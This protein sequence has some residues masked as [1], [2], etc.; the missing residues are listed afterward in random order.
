MIPPDI[1]PNE[2]A[3]IARLHS[4]ELLDGP[5]EPLIDRFTTLASGMTGM[6]I[7]LVSL[8]AESHAEVKSAVGSIAQGQRVPRALSFCSYAINSRG[9]FEVPDARQ[10]PRF[11]DNPAVRGERPVVHY[12]GAALVMPGDEAIGALCVV[13][14]KPGLLTAKDRLLLGSLADMLA[15]FLTLRERRRAHL[16]ELEA[17]N[18]AK[19]EFLATMSHEIRTP[20]HGV[21]GITQLLASSPLPPQ[22]AEYVRMIES[23]GKILLG[24]V[25]DILDLSKVEA[26]HVRLE[27]LRTDLHALLRELGQLQ[28]R[29]AGEKALWFELEVAPDVPQW[30]VTDPHRLRQVLLN[31]LGNAWKFTRNGGYALRAAVRGDATGPQLVLE[32]EDTGIGIPP[33]VQA[34][35]FTRFMQADASTTRRFSGTGLGLAIVREL[36]RLMGGDVVL[37]SEAGRGARFTVT[38][39]LVAASAEPARPSATAAPEVRRHAERILVADDNEVNLVVIEGLLRKLGYANVTCVRDGTEVVGAFDG[40]TF[41][42]VLMDCQMPA[43]DGFEATRRLRASGARLP[44]IALTASAVLGDE[45]R[46]I[47]AGMSGYLTKPISLPDLA[48]SLREAL[49]HRHPVPARAAS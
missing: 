3:R 13:D 49:E 32:V 14:H 30:I 21:L 6:P 31:L 36:A 45:E 15:E 29:R 35:L 10:D 4:L 33:E 41:D 11:H 26:G 27:S 18:R 5:P 23:S 2:Q 22:E 1:P 43:M 47:A 16:Q 7:S 12:A 17:A 39:P 28:D 40:A 38:L 44:I 34:R 24:L 20:I 48:D 42:L 46:C 8:I 9:V 25:N 37:T 19:S